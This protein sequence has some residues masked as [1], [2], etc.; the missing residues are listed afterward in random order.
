MPYS[1]ELGGFPIRIDSHTFALRLGNRQVRAQFVVPDLLPA[2]N[3][4]EAEALVRGLEFG[5]G[6]GTGIRW[7]HAAAW[8]TIQSIGPEVHDITYQLGARYVT[9]TEVP[10]EGYLP[11]DD[12]ITVWLRD[13]KAYRELLN[14]SRRIGPGAAAVDT[15]D[16]SKDVTPADIRF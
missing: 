12:E 2:A 5:E 13:N 7:L 10:V 15:E 16:Q 11:K 14:E 6:T 8:V 3:A 9:S 4:A 1:A